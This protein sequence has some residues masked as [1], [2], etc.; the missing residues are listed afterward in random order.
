MN[1]GKQKLD[2]EV[3]ILRNNSQQAELMF[4]QY[5]KKLND[6]ANYDNAKR[7][8]YGNGWRREQSQL[9]N[10][11]YFNDIDSKCKCIQFMRRKIKQ[12]MLLILKLLRSI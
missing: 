2:M 3:K 4:K 5:K 6:E 1:G 11:S 9:I 10:R 12:P 7:N 8:Q